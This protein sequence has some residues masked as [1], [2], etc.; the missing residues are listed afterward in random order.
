[1]GER[2]A[3]CLFGLALGDAL[4]APTEFIRDVAE[5]ERKYGKGGPAEP[6]G[7]PARVTDDTQVSLTNSAVRVKVRGERLSEV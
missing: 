6:L 4:A 5:I 7:N 3:G 2:A 1:M